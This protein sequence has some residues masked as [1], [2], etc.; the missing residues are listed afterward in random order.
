MRMAWHIGLE[1]FRSESSPFPFSLRSVRCYVRT[2][3]I[4][5]KIFYEAESKPVIRKL[6]ASEVSCSLS[7]R[8]RVRV[9][10]NET[11]EHQLYIRIWLRLCCAKT[12]AVK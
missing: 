8:E 1:D 6:Q 7:P 12:F 11:Q 2:S 9:R 10:G 4:L 3:H 5:A